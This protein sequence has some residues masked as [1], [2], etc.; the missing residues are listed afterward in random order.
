MS[1]INIDEIREILSKD[2]WK[3]LTDKYQNLETEMVFECAEG[4]KVY[5]P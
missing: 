5:A 2:G 1:R 4:H 3:L